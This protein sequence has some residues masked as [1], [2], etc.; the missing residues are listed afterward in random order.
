[1][2]GDFFSL[3]V[4]ANCTLYFLELLVFIPC[5]LRFSGNKWF[6][7]SF[8]YIFWQRSGILFLSLNLVS[9]GLILP[10]L[11]HNQGI[12]LPKWSKQTSGPSPDL[13]CFPQLYWSAKLLQIALIYSWQKCYIFPSNPLQVAKRSSF[14]QQ[15]TYYVTSWCAWYCFLLTLINMGSGNN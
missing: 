3:P 4:W 6:N 13:L 12:F 11:A 15:L 14:P 9:P 1:M 7:L 8:L 2:K 10:M 5:S